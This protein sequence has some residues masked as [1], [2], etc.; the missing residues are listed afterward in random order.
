MNTSIIEIQNLRELL[1]DK[2]QHEYLEKY[3]QKP[4]IDDE[5]LSILISL[6]NNRLSLSP[7]QK[8]QYIITAMMVQVALDTH[9]LVPVQNDSN[10]TNEEKLTKQLRVLAG[11]Y[12]SG[13]Y[14]LLLS[15]IEDFDFIH[16]LASAIKKINEYKIKLYYK[17]VESFD[18]F[19]ELTK[20]IDSAVILQV[21][22]FLYGS[23]LDQVI[24]DWLFTERM[25]REIREAHISGQ[26]P[27]YEAWQAIDQYSN[28]FSF[29]NKINGI[30]HKNRLKI[31]D[32]TSNLPDQY[33]FIKNHLLSRINETK[34]HDSPTAEE[35]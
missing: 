16:T 24:A 19:I 5:K 20:K 18:D 27:L 9:E 7:T 10:E 29:T 15:E 14:Y 22:Q 28:H 13:L 1:E 33:L 23:S 3:I 34:H 25:S 4:V 30:I 2:L 8:D 21:A 32:Q 12:Y 11:D 35:G 26:F 17:E 6:V 31:A